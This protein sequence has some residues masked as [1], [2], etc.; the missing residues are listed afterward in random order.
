MIAR[1]HSTGSLA[2]LPACGPR[3]AFAQAPGAFDEQ[4]VKA[5]TY[6]N[7]G[8]FRMGAR[9][10]AIA[11]PDGKDHLYTF[12]VGFWTGGCGRRRTTAPHSNR[13]SMATTG[14]LSAPSP[15]PRRT[16]TSCGSAPATPSRRELAAGDGVYKS[17]D[18]GK[19]WTNVGLKDSHHISASRSIRRTRTPSMSRRWVTSSPRMPS[20][21]VQ[22]VDGGKSWEKV[23]YVNEGVGVID[24]VMHPRNP[25]VLYAATYDKKRMPWQIVNGGPGTAIY[26]TLNG[27][28][29]WT[30]LAADCRR[31]RSAASV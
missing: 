18:A 25:A 21:G 1:L 20:A 15:P 11:V 28:R 26:K 19:T 6:R 23:L 4:T 7:V 8:P 24:L 17:L 5:L 9:V 16:R 30:K 31:A 13:S 3:R 12:Y 10:S 14:S 27:G 29:T 2:D 22:D